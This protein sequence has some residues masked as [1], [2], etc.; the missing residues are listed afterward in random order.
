MKYIISIAS[1]IAVLILILGQA[2]ASY[3]V[4][5]RHSRVIAEWLH[6]EIQELTGKEERSISQIELIFRKLAHLVE[7]IL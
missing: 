5:A 3:N 4:E 2:S 1:I 7:Y 6:E